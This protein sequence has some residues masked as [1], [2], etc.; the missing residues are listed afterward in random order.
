[1]F[2]LYVNI[3]RRRYLYLLARIDAPEDE[4]AF[5][6]VCATSKRA[7]RKIH[8]LGD[9]SKGRWCKY[10]DRKKLGVKKLNELPGD[11]PLGVQMIL[12]REPRPKVDSR[13]AF[14]D[15]EFI[16]WFEEGTP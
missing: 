11:T 4:P 2:S 13:I 1:M 15:A 6:V 3:W 8:P 5:V 16:K 7:A 14:T 10:E 12:A 9:W